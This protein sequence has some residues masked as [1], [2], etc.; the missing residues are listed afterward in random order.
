[1]NDNYYKVFDNNNNN[2]HL[3]INGKI[4]K[5]VNYPKN[6]NDILNI[7]IS[8]GNIVHIP[9]VNNILINYENNKKM[10]N[11]NNLNINESESDNKIKILSVKI[12]KNIMYQDILIHTNKNLIILQLYKFIKPIENIT[13]GAFIIYNNDYNDLNQNNT[14]FYT[15]NNTDILVKSSI[16]DI[17]LI[18]S[19]INNVFKYQ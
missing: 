9:M 6:L 18:D 2:D 5:I 13:H 15:K 7:D 19:R 8:Y 11:I 3:I 14:I 12:D 17:D 16:D 1:L 4:D 10:L